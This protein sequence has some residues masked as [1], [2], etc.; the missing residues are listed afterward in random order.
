[1]TDI[2]RTVLAIVVAALLAG[3]AWLTS[4]RVVT[5]QQFSDEGQ[6]LFPGFTD[7]LQARVLEVVAY[8]EETA[9]YR[10]FKVEFRD[11][12]WVIPSHDDYPVDAEENMAAAA[13]VLIGLTREQV[14]TDRAAEHE[15]LGVLAPDDDNAPISGR[16]VRV[17]FSDGSGTQ[18]ASLIIGHA[19]NDTTAGSEGARRYVR[20]AGK[21]RVYAA[22][23]NHTFSTDFRDWVETDL[24][25][26]T[27]QTID[28][29]EVDRYSIDERAG[30]KT[31]SRR[32][33][34]SRTYDP[35][36]P[37]SARDWTVRETLAG[38]P[39]PT[40]AGATP[41][42]EA[43]ND[44][45]NEIKKIRISGVRPK[46]QRLVE[47]FEGRT[48]QVDVPEL[49]NLQSRGFFVDQNGQLLANEG[50]VR[51]T[52]RDGVVL[53][54]YFGEVL[55]GPAAAV[56][57]GLGDVVNAS[58]ESDGAGTEHRYM[59]VV[60]SFDESMFPEPQA[61]QAAGQGEDATTSGAQAAYEQALAA[62]QEKLDAGRSRADALRA[63]YANWY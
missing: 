37:A 6:L 8:D 9:S 60:A 62:R 2:A 46:P 24:L 22:T 59:F 17:T 19:V 29:Y 40:P 32:L 34:M 44:V 25:Q 16:G 50:E 38:E 30:T 43:I 55:Y 49:M 51:V 10:A 33:S 5:D 52:T 57:S 3:G 7:P 31:A 4:P 12:Q 36:V 1:M 45:L 18:L 23:F 14:I 42:V 53:T 39:V 28:R 63:R 58:T 15:S 41:D 35:A 20:I 48:N 11:R 61:P 27:G 47:L 56:S 26:L 54:M 13:S 21:N